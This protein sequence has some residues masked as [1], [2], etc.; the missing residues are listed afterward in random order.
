MHLIELHVNL[1]AVHVEARGQLLGSDELLFGHLEVACVGLARFDVVVGL[2]HESIDLLL[3]SRVHGHQDDFGFILVDSERHV[4]LLRFDSLLACFQQAAVPQQSTRFDEARLCLHLGVACYRARRRERYVDVRLPA[5][6]A[7]PSRHDWRLPIACPG[8][9]HSA[10]RHRVR[11]RRLRG[12]P[13]LAAVRRGALAGHL[14]IEAGAD[15]SATLAGRHSGR[16]KAMQPGWP[17]ADW[18]L[19][20][21][22]SATLV[23]R[24]MALEPAGWTVRW[25]Q[26]ACP[27]RLLEP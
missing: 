5:G 11:S 10:I 16:H 17:F 1:V 22:C 19:A 13:T 18:K 8:R 3:A 21:D 9:G 14:L 20:P 23:G 26:A 25:R 7:R 2:P 6:L 15:C 24:Q 12:R 4:H 27:W